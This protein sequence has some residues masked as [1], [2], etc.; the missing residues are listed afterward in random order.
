MAHDVF[1]SYSTKDKPIADAVC[2]TLEGNGIRCWIAPRDI[3]PGLDWGEAI[4]DGISESQ[5]MVLVFSSHANSSPQVRREVQRAF[6]KSITVV[7]LRVEEVIPHRSLE[8][9]ISQIHWLDA[10]TLPLEKHLQGLADAINRLLKRKTT[11]TD[12]RNLIVCHNCDNKMPEEVKFCS[13]CGQ[14]NEDGK[15]HGEIKVSKDSDTRKKSSVNV[16]AR[17]LA[18]HTDSVFSVAF[19]PDNKTIASGSRDASIILWDSHTGESKLKMR[20]DSDV[21]KLCFS[22]DGK[23]L[24]SLPNAEGVYHGGKEIHLWNTESGKVEWILDNEVYAYSIAFSPDGQLLAVASGDYTVKI[25]HL[26]EENLQ[27]TLAAENRVLSVAFSP[28]GKTLVSGDNEG[29]L[30]LWDMQTS[31]MKQ[32]IK[33][34][35]YANFV[36]FSPDGKTLAC[37]LTE[38]KQVQLIDAYTGALQKRLNCDS[39]TWGINFS[40]DGKCLAVAC[41]DNSVKLWNMDTSKLEQSL[42]GHSSLVVDVAFSPDAKRLASGSWDNTVRIWDVSGLFHEG[43]PPDNKFAVSRSELLSQSSQIE[44]KSDERGAQLTEQSTALSNA[45]ESKELKEVIIAL[46]LSTGRPMTFIEIAGKVGDMTTRPNLV[47]LLSEL[48]K[49]GLIEVS[50]VNKYSPALYKLGSRGAS[51]Q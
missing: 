2:A 9:Y 30:R 8:Y 16:T 31:E 39:E 7:P 47:N 19:S 42:K 15:L 22:P 33:L 45:R 27:Q 26:Q 11:K 24:A 32:S 4:I 25:W 20:H 28:D 40:S 41:S 23:M 38:T 3:L 43:K 48:R 18:G 46:L 34:D 49:S 13:V 12:E 21:L 14:P 51:G 36:E 5:V 37:S 17:P 44:G 35:A 10:L 50:A 1:I 29:E 6:E